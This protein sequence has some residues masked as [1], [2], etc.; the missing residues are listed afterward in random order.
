MTDDLLNG[1]VPP[2]ALTMSE[3]ESLDYAL[4]TYGGELASSVAEGKSTWAV[5][6][7]DRAVWAMS[8]L[9]QLERD[10]DLVDLAAKRRIDIITAWRAA[11]TKEFVRG[12]E[13]FTYLLTRFHQGEHAADERRI[14]IPLPDGTLVSRKTQQKLEFDD[15]RF[16][17]WAQTRSEAEQDQL[18]KRK[19]EVSKTGA[20]QL[21][22]V[23]ELVAVADRGTP[24]EMVLEV[25]GSTFELDDVAYRIEG[26]AVVTL[27]G[28]AFPIAAD[29]TIDIGGDG[30]V[31]MVQLARLVVTTVDMELVPGA[32][33]VPEGRS[34]A[35]KVDPAVVVI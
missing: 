31:R 2:L 3:P 5:D 19:P 15:D 27:N 1:F 6:S 8:K 33:A 9:A 23:H 7:L 4:D 34:F 17:G 11:N 25:I 13:Y 18:L 28:E 29:G 20:K 26:D 22:K 30:E 16:I 10:K 24:D 21:L 12:I 32:T 35:V 14:S